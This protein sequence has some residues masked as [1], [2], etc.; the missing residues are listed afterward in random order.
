MYLDFARRIQ[1]HD[2]RR[3]PRSRKSL[4]LQPVSIDLLYPGSHKC[5]SNDPFGGEPF[6]PKLKD[7]THFRGLTSQ[8]L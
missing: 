1:R 8:N 4:G 6:V 3:H 7:L 5:Y 2:P